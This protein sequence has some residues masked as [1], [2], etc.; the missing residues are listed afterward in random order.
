M[1]QQLV[2]RRGYRRFRGKRIWIVMMLNPSTADDNQDD[3]TIRRCMGFARSWGFG[4]LSVVNLFAKRST[5]PDQL[6]KGFGPIVGMENDAWIDSQV[7]TQRANG[8]PVVAAWGACAHPGAKSRARSVER[9]WGPFV[10]LG[11]T[12]DGSPRHPL[13]VPKHAQLVPYQ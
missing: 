5:D 13:Y 12:K 3:P 6:F 2:I 8:W 1:K 11:T 4:W 9:V 7:K 10:C